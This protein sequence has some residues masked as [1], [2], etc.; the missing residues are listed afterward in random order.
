MGDN[1]DT[2]EIKSNRIR[3]QVISRSYVETRVNKDGKVQ[4][5]KEGKVIKRVVDDKGDRY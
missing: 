4:V 1:I 2:N 3:Q 5:E